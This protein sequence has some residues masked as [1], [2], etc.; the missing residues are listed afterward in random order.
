MLHSG[1]HPGHLWDCADSPLLSTQGMFTLSCLCVWLWWHVTTSM[2]S[3]GG[4]GSVHD[5]CV[6]A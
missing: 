2:C 3:A 4:G 1:C 6:C 5:A